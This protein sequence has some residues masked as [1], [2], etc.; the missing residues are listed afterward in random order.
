MKAV[1]LAA[2]LG[3]RLRPLTNHTPKCLVPINGEPL[4]ANWLKKLDGLGVK[5]FLINTHYLHE[6]VEE[7]IYQSPYKDRIHISY[8][9]RLLGTAGTL[10]NNKV[11]WSN[12]L[13]W[14]IHAD[15]YCA[16]NLEEMLS[17]HMSKPH[18]IDVTL[19]LFHTET[20]HN[21]GIVKLDNHNVITEFH[22]K[23]PNPPGNLASGAL[24]LFSP[25]VYKR[26]FYGL[27]PMHHYELSLDVLPRMVGSMQ[28]WK[29]HRTYLDIGTPKNY[30]KV[31][32]LNME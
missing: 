10:I 26:Y 7:F 32:G 15:N 4:L 19:L 28:G 29:T 11:F 9:P 22:E 25:N 24:F 17:K 3:T 13:C 14:V 30:Y 6:Q 2:G 27:K 12:E 23:V 16:D 1:L 5:E 20:P 18:N 8:E 31:C 21:C